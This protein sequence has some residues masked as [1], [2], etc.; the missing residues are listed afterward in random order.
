MVVDSSLARS[1]SQF[2]TYKCRCYVRI[3]ELDL[4]DGLD[5]GWIV[6][7]EKQRLEYVSPNA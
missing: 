3:W 7:L 2:P 5:I 4:L 6:T 1:L